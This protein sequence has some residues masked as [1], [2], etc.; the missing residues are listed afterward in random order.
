M[1]KLFTDGFDHVDNPYNIQT[2]IFFNNDWYSFA[3]LSVSYDLGST[4]YKCR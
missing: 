1:H 3:T 2:S 4:A